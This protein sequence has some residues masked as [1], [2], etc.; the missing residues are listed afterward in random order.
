M[1]LP[2]EFPELEPIRK[3]MA[4]SLSSSTPPRHPG[5]DACPTETPAAPLY[6]V[7]TV[8]TRFRGVLEPMCTDDL[9]AARAEALT[10][11]ASH[12]Q[13]R[14]CLIVNRAGGAVLFDSARR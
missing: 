10:R 8:D 7:V 13:H 4:A 11:A 9:D 3:K 2:T 14:T 5:R 6:R 1:K 12:P